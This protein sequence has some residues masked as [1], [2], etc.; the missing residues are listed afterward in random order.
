MLSRSSA[1]PRSHHLVMICANHRYI[2]KEGVCVCVCWGGGGGG[3]IERL[4]VAAAC[5]S[6]IMRKILIIIKNKFNFLPVTATKRN[7]SVI[8]LYL[9]M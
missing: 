3:V 4:P 7:Y 5:G 8:I 2:T 1:I 9:Y 6:I